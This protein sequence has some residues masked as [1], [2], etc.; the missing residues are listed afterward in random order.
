MASPEF[1]V[2]SN[3][4]YPGLQ[5]IIDILE[6][7]VDDENFSYINPGYPHLSHDCRTHCCIGGHAQIALAI[8]SMS[9]DDADVSGIHDKGIYQKRM[10]RIKEYCTETYGVSMQENPDTGN[11]ES[12][13]SFCLRALCNIPQNVAEDL[14]FNLFEILSDMKKTKPGSTQREAVIAI[15]QHCRDTGQIEIPPGWAPPLT[16][17]QIELQELAR[18]ALSVQDA[19][20]LCGV[21]QGFARAMSRLRK[22]YPDTSVYNSHPIAH[23]WIN[24]MMD[25]SGTDL[26][27]AC[28][29]NVQEIIDNPPAI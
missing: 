14:C 3:P 24:K 17:N 12:A 25:L 9:P 29:A 6:Y 22:L 8:R 4:V 21:A 11:Q 7:L 26:D 1:P 23:A 28:F 2:Q 16:E 20:N 5:N 27:G 10:S 13:I 15:L 19:C 18:E